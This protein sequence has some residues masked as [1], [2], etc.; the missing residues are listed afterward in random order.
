MMVDERRNEYLKM[1]AD[2]CRSAH[3]R[4]QLSRCRK[5]RSS[6]PPKYVVSRT[7]IRRCSTRN[8]ERGPEIES[9]ASQIKSGTQ[10][11]K[12]WNGAGTG[13]KNLRR[14]SRDMIIRKCCSAMS[15][16]AHFSKTETIRRIVRV[17]D[18]ALLSLVPSTWRSSFLLTPTDVELHQRGTFR[19]SPGNGSL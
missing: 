18:I 11:R 4:I 7:R 12:E 13:A 16:V 6:G 3:R 15:S 1:M 10:G 5:N 17:F 8:L 9:M 19:S 2:E 14:G